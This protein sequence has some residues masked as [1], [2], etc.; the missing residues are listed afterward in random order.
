MPHKLLTLAI[1]ALLS[2]AA[3]QAAHAK[4]PDWLQNFFPQQEKE[5]AADLLTFKKSPLT[6]A[7]RK[8]ERHTFTAEM[9]MTPPQQTQGL[10]HREHLDENAAMLFWF[11]E[12]QLLAFWMRNTL[13]PLDMIFV[14]KD[15][16][17]V[18]IHSNAKPLDETRVPS[19]RPAAAVVEINGGQAK[20]Q[21]IQIGD[22]IIHP[23]FLNTLAE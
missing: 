23:I 6:I 12:E 7:T 1:I 18:H 20:K 3:P 8:G 2:F 17:I 22:K 19:L 15:G 21:D 11:G 5:A 13:I 14:A 9:A 4:L 16:T 10:M